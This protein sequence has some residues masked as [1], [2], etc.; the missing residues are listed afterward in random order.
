M[1]SQGQTPNSMSAYCSTVWWK[2]S[3]TEIVW[4]FE[5]SESV[6][7]KERSTE[8]TLKV[9]KSLTPLQSHAHRYIAYNRHDL[10]RNAGRSERCPVRDHAYHPSDIPMELILLTPELASGYT[11]QPVSM[12]SDTKHAVMDRHAKGPTSNGPSLSLLGATAGVHFHTSNNSPPWSQFRDSSPMHDAQLFASALFFA[13]PPSFSAAAP[14]ALG[15]APWIMTCPLTATC[16]AS[17]KNIKVGMAV[18]L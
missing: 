13:S 4:T 3:T 5:M 17:L 16:L 1:L 6:D 10:G 15:S 14:S 7:K 2:L 11:S 18:T 9:C 12:K 8:I